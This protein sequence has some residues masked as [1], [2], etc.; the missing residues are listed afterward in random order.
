MNVLTKALAVFSL[1]FSTFAAFASSITVT[2]G[3]VREVI[4]GNSVTSAYMT[5]HNDS[6]AAV[7]LVSAKSAAI[8]VI[9]IHEHTMADGMMKM[10]QVDFIEIAAGSQVVLQPMGLHLMMFDLS[11]PLKA[12]EQLALTLVFDNNQ[13]LNVTLPVQSI[14]Q[15]KH[16]H[17]HH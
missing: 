7:K 11:K 15:A 4:P 13:T 16:N 14:K 17:H 9:E 12:G 6:A 2:D 5:I 3:Y 1:F 8:P 10:G